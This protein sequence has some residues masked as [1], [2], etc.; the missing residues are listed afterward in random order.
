MRAAIRV[1]LTLKIRSGPA[2]GR[3]VLDEVAQIAADCGVDAITLHP[4]TR[5]QGFA[6]GAD[7]A[8]ISR[9]RNMW[10]GPLVGNGDVTSAEGAMRMMADTGCDA[11]MIGRAAIGNPWIFGEADA[12]WRGLPLP[13]RPDNLAL[14]RT[15]LRHF[16]LMTEHV[17][18]EEAAARVFRKHLH[19]YVRGI[20][21][22]LDVRRALPN[23]I[24]RASLMKALALVGLVLRA[25]ENT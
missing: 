13:K 10:R 2:T 7:W 6:G 5:A 4:R 19:R 14:M 17:G 8:L 25:R 21:G 12:A 3:L 20:P 18:D 1:P 22:A 9:F 24:S 23:V 11:V 15:I 16:D